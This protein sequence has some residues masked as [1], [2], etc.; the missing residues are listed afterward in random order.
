SLPV[1]RRVSL[2]F[3]EYAGRIATIASKANPAV[4]ILHL[5]EPGWLDGIDAHRRQETKYRVESCV[6]SNQRKHQ[7]T[8]FESRF[9]TASIGTKVAGGAIKPIAGTAVTSDNT[10]LAH[11]LE[12]VIL[13]STDLKGVSGRL[14]LFVQFPEQHSQAKVGRITLAGTPIAYRRNAATPVE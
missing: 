8:S 11:D 4:G 2:D 12:T 1:V 9:K 7:R 14:D 10:L 6:T 3:L 13:Q 5:S